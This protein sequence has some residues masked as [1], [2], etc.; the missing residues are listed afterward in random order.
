M[1]WNAFFVAAE[2]S[3]VTVR[4]TRLEE[5]I[6]QGSR[7]AKAVMRIVDDLPTFISAV[8]LAITLSSLALGAVGEP[9]FSR[10]VEDILGLTGASREGLA[11]TI[12]VIIAFAVITTLH[13]V[14]GEIVPKTFT[15]QNAERVAL[16]AAAPVRLFYNCFRPFIWFLDWLAVATARILGLPEPRLEL[17]RPLGGGAE[18]PR[19]RVQGRGQDRGRGAGDGEQ[20]L[21]RS[22]T[23][24]WTR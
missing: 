13:T 21:R 8:Q 18:A 9:A 24:R 12:S 20:G 7:R 14:L 11:S 16:V 17:A 1:A 3:F 15:L 22:P 2:Y 5:L 10:L 23:P 4:R 6:E 19:R